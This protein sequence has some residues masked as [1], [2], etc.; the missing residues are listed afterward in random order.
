MKNLYIFLLL[1]LI[2]RA[3]W[4]TINGIR[5]NKN[6]AKEDTSSFMFAVGLE[7]SH[8]TEIVIYLSILY[9][10]IIIFNLK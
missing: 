9:W 1:T 3:V 8:L 4:I 6:K 2:I 7:T 10:G 5:Y